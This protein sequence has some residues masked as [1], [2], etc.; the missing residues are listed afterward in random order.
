MVV[1]G[2]QVNEAIAVHHFRSS[3][4]SRA[5][6]EWQMAVGKVRARLPATAIPNQTAHPPASARLNS[7]ESVHSNQRDGAAG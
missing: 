1:P 3:L 6:I 7:I 5:L 2:V 4:G